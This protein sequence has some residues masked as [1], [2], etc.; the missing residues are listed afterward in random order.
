MPMT[1]PTMKTGK[2]RSIPVRLSSQSCTRSE[3]SSAAG[4]TSNETMPLTRP[5]TCLGV[6]SCDHGHIA[7]S[8]RVRLIENIVIEPNRT[9]NTRSG[10]PSSIG[11]MS[12][13]SRKT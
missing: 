4:S 6:Y 7:V 13:G 9:Q 11:A 3:P 12:Q 8:A 5:R 2:K 10:L 1:M